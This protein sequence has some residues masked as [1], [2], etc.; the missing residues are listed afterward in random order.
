MYVRID[1][2]RKVPWY[3]WRVWD[4]RRPQL[5]LRQGKDIGRKE[6]HGAGIGKVT[7]G[8]PRIR[9]YTLK[10]DGHTFHSNR[11]PERSGINNTISGHSWDDLEEGGR[12]WRET[13]EEDG[14][15]YRCTHDFVH[16][17]KDNKG[18]PTRKTNNNKHTLFFIDPYTNRNE[19]VHEQLLT[20]YFTF[21]TYT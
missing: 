16:S 4:C 8:S 14:V 12:G 9:L 13:V 20:H 2:G 19:Q 10:V 17:R 6:A 21:I 5:C 11:D 3:F 18:T 15:R 1:R 7:L